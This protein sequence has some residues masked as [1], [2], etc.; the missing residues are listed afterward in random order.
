VSELLITSSLDPVKEGDVFTKGLPCHVTIW[1]YFT[2]PDSHMNEFIA[3]IGAAIAAFQPLEIVAYTGEPDAFGPN[4]DV[5]VRRV[6]ALGAGA[7]LLTLHAV[8]GERIE[9][10]EG[11]IRNPEWAYEGFNPHVT[12]VQGEALSEGEHAALTT[13]ELIEKNTQL[14]A[15]TVRKI[16]ELEE[17]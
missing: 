1:Q 6:H 4:N 3:D 15:K 13:I 14:K 7:T 17:A 8:L 11:T 2:L 5:P 12:Y 16:W 9:H 10:Y